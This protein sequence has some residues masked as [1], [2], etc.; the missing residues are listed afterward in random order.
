MWAGHAV[1]RGVCYVFS[2]PKSL[3]TALSLYPSM[4]SISFAKAEQYDSIEDGDWLLK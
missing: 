4:R 2:T 3:D 1:Y